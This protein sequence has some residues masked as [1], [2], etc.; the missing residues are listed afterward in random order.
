MSEFDPYQHSYRQAVND[1]IAFS[2]Q[3]VDFFTRVKV[4]HLLNTAGRLVGPAQQLRVLDIGCGAGLTDQLLKTRVGHLAGV[5]VSQGLLTTAREQN[6]GV[7]YQYYDGGKLPWPDGSFDVAFAICVM[8]HVP[9]AQ[10]EHFAREAARV[11]RPG[12]CVA[13]YEHN[14]L[15]PLTRRIVNQCPFDANAVLLGRSR[16]RG[17]LRAAGLRV[18]GQPYLLFFPWDRPVWRTV[19]GALGWL[20]LGAQYAVWAKKG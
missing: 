13:I 1:A 2:G 8:H 14:P 9:P 3:T 4:E 5:D 6:P 19:E 7:E 12:G 15:N 11:V 18:V 17:L 20:P 10:W 16:T